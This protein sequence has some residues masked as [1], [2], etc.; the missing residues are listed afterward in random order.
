MKA[1]FHHGLFTAHDIWHQVVRFYY[2]SQAIN[3]GQFPPY[4]ISKLANRFGYPLFMFSYPLPWLIG[5]LLLRIGF[6]FSNSIKILFFLSYFISGITM[7]F[8]ILCLLKDRLA[9]LTS[10]L[11]YL[12]LPY[13][14]LIIFVGASMGVAFVFI[15]LPLIFLGIHLLTRRSSFAIP[16]LA[17]GL[18]GVILSHVMHLIFLLPTIL[19]FINWEFNY[20]KSKTYFMK[21]LLYGALLAILLSSFYLLPATYYNQYTRIHQ[22]EGMTKLYERNFITINQLIYSKWGVSPIIN[23]AKDGEISFQLGIVQWISILALL[24]L[25]SLRKIPL[26]YK[27]LTVYLIFSFIVNIFLMLDISSPVWKFVVKYFAL[28]FPF[29]LILPTT[30]IAS[31]GAGILLVNIPKKTRY[32]IFLFLIFIA[33]YTNRN[34][35]NINQYTDFPISNYLD[36]ETERTTN[37]FNEYLPIK[38]NPRL[39]GKPWNEASGSSMLSYDTKQSTNNLFFKIDVSDD[40]KISVGQF[41]FP[42]Q[43]VY[44]DNKISKFEV[45]T[46]GLISLTTPKGFHTLEIKYNQTP[47]I[48]LSNALTLIGLFIVILLLK[49]TLPKKLASK[50]L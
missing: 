48:K 33:I 1:L 5:T 46:N 20:T 7:Y 32:F 35:I 27:S 19:L 39:L 38:A 36:L 40:T 41:Y 37:T 29:R 14:F 45:D 12:W 3:D 43:T 11:I 31:L 16:V 13:H 44:M 42:G 17:V 9:A 26:N 28:D 25:L 34:H 24:I 23:N 8:F 49:N 18:A 4:W 50:Y 15:F 2:Y 22:E 47:L 21:N 30:F 6:D 10:S